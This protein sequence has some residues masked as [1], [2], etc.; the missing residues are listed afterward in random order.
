[1]ENERRGTVRQTQAKGRGE[2]M[3]EVCRE[4]IKTKRVREADSH[5]HAHAHTWAEPTVKQKSQEST[6]I[7]PGKALK[8]LL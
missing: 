1:M 6:G 4:M 8:R 5:S 3:A 2:W 7:Y